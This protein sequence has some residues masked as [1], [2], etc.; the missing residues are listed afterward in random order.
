MRA[1]DSAS[2]LSNSKG[3][4]EPMGRA[5]GLPWHPQPVFQD[6]TASRSQCQ[7]GSRVMALRCHNDK[8]QLQPVDQGM[9]APYSRDGIVER[10]S[11]RRSKA[12][13]SG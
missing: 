1:S 5:D 9:V 4:H 7:S 12:E 6:N 8:D 11:R 3:V 2:V 13:R 10:S